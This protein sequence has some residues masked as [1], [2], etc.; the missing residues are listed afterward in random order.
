MLTEAGR[1][2]LP[3]SETLEAY[4]K[5]HWVLTD[6][7]ELDIRYPPEAGGGEYHHVP[8]EAAK[9][10]PGIWRGEASHLCGEDTYRGLYS[11]QAARLLVLHEV[12]GP[13]KNY[14]MASLYLR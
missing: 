9:D 3:E 4:S 2:H 10:K 11:L 1:L 5:W 14:R 7:G 6:K 8:I 12:T 13:E